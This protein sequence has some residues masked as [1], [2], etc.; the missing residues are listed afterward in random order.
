[1]PALR[2]IDGGAPSSPQP[3]ARCDRTP[4]QTSASV[5]GLGFRFGETVHVCFEVMLQDTLPS[6]SSIPSARPVLSYHC[7]STDYILLYA[8][9]VSLCIAALCAAVLLHPPCGSVHVCGCGPTPHDT[10][11]CPADRTEALQERSVTHRPDL[12][13]TMQSSWWHHPAYKTTDTDCSR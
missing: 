10:T 5:W 1:M 6:P 7:Y 12:L 9:A 4:V 2:R 11:Q 13:P 3:T 8:A